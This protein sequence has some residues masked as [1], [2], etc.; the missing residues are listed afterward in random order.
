[1][2]NDEIIRAWKDEDYRNSLSEEQRSQLPEN[3]AGM[4][5]EVVELTP[6]ELE[7]LKGGGNYY[8]TKW[9]FYNTKGGFCPKPTVLPNGICIDPKMSLQPTCKF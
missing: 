9:R 1:M 5:E 8:N 4:P 6:E 2:T 7:E 3:P